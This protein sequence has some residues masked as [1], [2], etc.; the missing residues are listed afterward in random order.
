MDIKQPLESLYSP[1]NEN[2][3]LKDVRMGHYGLIFGTVKDVC[4][5]Y[6]I[7]I[8]KLERCNEFIAPKLRIQMLKEKLHFSRTPYSDK[9]F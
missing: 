1:V 7:I 9:P 2:T 8:N 3:T 6:G 4:K 5:Q